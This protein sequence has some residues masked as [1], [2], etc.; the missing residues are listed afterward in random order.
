[1][2]SHCSIETTAYYLPAILS[3]DRLAVSSRNGSRRLRRFDSPAGSVST[4]DQDRIRAHNIPVAKP[5]VLPQLVTAFEAVRSGKVRPTPGSPRQVIYT[6]DG[7]SFRM[8][9]PNHAVR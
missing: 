2:P 8:R 5:G 6:V 7:F 3:R 1:M 4:A 9:A